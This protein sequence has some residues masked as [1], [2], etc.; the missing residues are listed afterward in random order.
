MGRR[1]P[2]HGV[3][4][5]RMHVFDVRAA[6]KFS[7]S[8]ILRH[9]C[10]AQT[11]STGGGFFLLFSGWNSLKCDAARVFLAC[12]LIMHMVRHTKQLTCACSALHQLCYPHALGVLNQNNFKK[13]GCNQKTKKMS[14][15]NFLG[16]NANSG[17]ADDREQSYMK[18]KIGIFRQKMN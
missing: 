7:P 1:A 6:L 10:V 12:N 17:T 8:F 5:L 14:F 9:R 18:R 4:T 2:H 3:C 16:S 15:A 11:A 13:S